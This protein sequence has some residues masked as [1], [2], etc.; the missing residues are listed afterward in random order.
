MNYFERQKKIDEIFRGLI[1][2]LESS[3]KAFVIRAKR[4][5][6]DWPDD[7]HQDDEDV[8]TIPTV[9]KILLEIKQPIPVVVE[10]KCTITAHESFDLCDDSCVLSLDFSIHWYEY[11]L[12]EVTV[13]VIANDLIDFI[14]DK[15]KY[16]NWVNSVKD[17]LEKVNEST[18][19]KQF[20]L[21]DYWNDNESPK[22]ECLDNSCQWG[23]E[24]F[25][26][27][28]PK[29]ADLQKIYEDIKRYSSFHGVEY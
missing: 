15:I 2:K 21:D 20:R 10:N 7:E 24:L 12:K 4:I 27:D 17:Y 3:G 25:S 16:N 11:D 23:V 9:F 14:D 29:F 22:I 5:N 28:V 18:G 8:A 1:D 6:D 26:F 13:D 19:N